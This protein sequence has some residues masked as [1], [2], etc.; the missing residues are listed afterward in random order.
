MSLAPAGTESLRR[1]NTARV[2]RSLREEGPAGRARLAERTGLSRATVGAIVADLTE[3]TIVTEGSSRAQG[4]GRPVRPVAL[5]RGAVLGL[6]MEVNVDY[7]AAAAVDLAGQ[8]V[9]TRTLPSEVP[10]AVDAVGGLAA[11][12]VTELGEDRFVGACLAVP[13]LIDRDRRTVAWAP[14]LRWEGVRPAD[15]LTSRLGPTLGRAIVVENDANL[16]AVAEAHHGAALD[17][18][19]ALYLTGTVGLGGGILESGRLVR[20]G[21]GFAG[22]IGHLPFGDRDAKCGCGRL[23]C[24]EASVGLEAMLELTGEP[25]HDDPV[26]AAAG[27]AARADDPSVRGAL[28]ELG[29]RIGLGIASLTSIL[30]P[31]VVVLGGYFA[32]LSPWLLPAADEAVIARLPTAGRRRPDLRAGALGIDAAAL[33][34]AEHAL[35][36]VIDGSAALPDPSV[37]G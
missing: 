20:G 31:D 33:G 12:L 22:E 23:G 26:A 19:H 30:D 21:G 5:R 7:V 35:G 9:A 14:N 6:G 4:R 10:D 17:H 18:Q 1:Q 8:V 11:A 2:L 3:R 24:W 36:A 25:P 34:A 16:A 15:A 32:P 37:A 29:R 27:V 13:G 28:E